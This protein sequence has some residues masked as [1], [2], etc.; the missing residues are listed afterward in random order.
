MENNPALPQ[1]LMEV[2]RYFADPVVCLNFMVEL[3]WPNGVTCP[4]C[5]ALEPKF[6]S[7]RRVWECRGCKKQFSVKLGT[8]LE[9]S[10]SLG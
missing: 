7:T 3:R 1:T 8:I 6:I 5:Q 9:D 2:I 10:P 4:R